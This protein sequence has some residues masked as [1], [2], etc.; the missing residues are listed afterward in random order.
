MKIQLNKGKVIAI[1][2]KGK[3]VRYDDASAPFSVDKNIGESLIANG[4]AV[5]VQDEK[6]D[7]ETKSELK[8]H[9]G[10]KSAAPGTKEASGKRLKEE[11]TDEIQG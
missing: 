8:E 6:S 10:K 5:L 9:A 4:S 7:S 2:E 1:R 3:L 11:Q